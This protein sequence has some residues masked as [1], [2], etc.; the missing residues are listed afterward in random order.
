MSTRKVSWLGVCA[1]IV[2]AAATPAFAQSYY[3]SSSQTAVVNCFVYNAVATNLLPLHSGMTLPQFQAYSVAVSK[4]LQSQQTYLVVVG[5]SSAIA[6]AMPAT[7]AN[8]T[9]DGA[10]QQAASTAIVDAEIND[11]IIAVPA[12]ATQANM[13]QFSEDVVYIMDQNTG[14][15]LSPGMLLRVIDSYVVTATSGTT[16]NWSTADSGLATL[17]GNLTSTGML[18]LPASL[19]AAQVQQFVQDVALAIYNYKQTTGRTTL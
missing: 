2:A 17:I 7:D 12:G 9:S 8:G 4:I 6:D 18:K 13:E 14:I 15:T 19:T 10:A 1:V 11:G 16:V 3:C 5:M